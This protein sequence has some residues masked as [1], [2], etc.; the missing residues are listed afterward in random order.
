MQLTTQQFVYL[1]GTWK[2][3]ELDLRVFIIFDH[4]PLVHVH[5]SKGLKLRKNIKYQL[6]PAVPLAKKEHKEKRKH[7]ALCLALVLVVTLRVAYGL[8]WQSR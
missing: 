1:D 5:L 8:A 6:F 4:F 2:E 3:K 7:T